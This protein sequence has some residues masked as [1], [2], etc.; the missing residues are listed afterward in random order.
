LLISDQRIESISAT[1]SE[2]FFWRD[3]RTGDIRHE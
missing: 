2:V 1:E 3:R